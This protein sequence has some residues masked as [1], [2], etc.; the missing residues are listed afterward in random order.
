MSL[1]QRFRQVKKL[2][3]WIFAP[4]AWLLHT[5]KFFMRTEIIDRSG[6]MTTHTP[7]AVT[8]TWHN[9]LLFFPVMFPRWQRTH[10]MAVISA[11]RDGQYISDLVKQMGIESLR[12]SSSKKG[13][14][15]LHG[16]VKAVQ[17]GK[18]VS[19]TPDGP[20]GPR[21]RMSTGPIYL[22]SQMRVPVIP[23]A[24][25]YTSCWSLKS[26]DGFQIPK[27]WAK[28]TLLIGE[29]IF[30]PENLNDEELEKYRRL[31]E[32]KLNEV[33]LVKERDIVK[34]GKKR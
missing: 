24:I 2:P 33:S 29:K 16:A 8:V 27:P 12:G 15:A 21:Y 17:A 19:F 13:F 31:V 14:N 23:I 25:N 7:P 32:V 22:A 11:S 4:A 26:W 18:Y 20:R 34:S 10:T 1:K 30:I 28:V 3:D 6:E 5:L 9:R